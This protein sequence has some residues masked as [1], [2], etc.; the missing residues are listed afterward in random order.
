MEEGPAYGYELANRFRNMT[1]GHIRVSYGTVYPFLRTMERRGLIH[2]KRDKRTRRVYYELTER[3]LK[4]QK[5]ISKRVNECRKDMEEKLLGVLSIHSAIF[6]R[7]ALKT[8]L[9]E[10]K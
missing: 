4:E 5:R 2:S 3:G 9:K 1:G 8:L 10:I 7:T 6:G